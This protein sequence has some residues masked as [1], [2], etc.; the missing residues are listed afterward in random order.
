MKVTE[1]ETRMIINIADND[2]RDGGSLD[3]PVWSDCLDCG[4]FEIEPAKHGGLIASLAKKGLVISSGE[5]VSLTR[6]GV[7]VYLANS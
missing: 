1:L 2:Y 5:T 6:A 3:A 7:E 4:P